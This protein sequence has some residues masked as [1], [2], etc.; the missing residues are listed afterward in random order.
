MSDDESGVF[1]AEECE[2][3][4]LN[5]DPAQ[6]RIYLVQESLCEES[7]RILLS[8]HQLPALALALNK[9]HSAETSKLPGK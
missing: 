6:L 1:T 2:G 9:L 4:R 7:S 3:W 5:Y 8:L